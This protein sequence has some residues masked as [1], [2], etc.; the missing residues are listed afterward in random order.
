[1][2]IEHELSVTTME[3][4]QTQD[5][6]VVVISGKNCGCVAAFRPISRRRSVT[7]SER[8]ERSQTQRLQLDEALGVL[9]V[10]DVVF[11]K[12]DDILSI[13]TAGGASPP[14]HGHAA[15]EEP[16]S[17]LAV[18]AHLRRVDRRLEHLSLR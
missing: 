1:M 14:E 17:H 11:L 12:G 7:G 15:L 13:E 3:K 16:E 10:V 6:V 8:S 5:A 9:L 18:D 4:K 2:V